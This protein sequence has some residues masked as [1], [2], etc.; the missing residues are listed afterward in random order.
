MTAERGEDIARSRQEILDAIGST[1]DLAFIRPSGTG[2]LGDELIWAGTRRLLGDRAY[3]EI[4]V[5]E[6]PRASG[7][8]ALICGGG[9][10]CHSRHELMP[11]VLAVAE[12]RFERVILLPSSFDTSVDV[13]RDTLAR[14][15]A[16]IFARER[17]S[18]ALIRELCDARIAH[19]CA[20]FFD[21]ASHARTGVGRLLA[22][23]TDAESAGE[24]PIP[25][26][27]DDISLT[28]PTLDRW[29]ELIAGHELIWT[30]R[31][32]V[33]I[34]GAMLGKTVEYAPSDYFK[35]P[36]LADYALDGFPVRRMK[37]V[38]A[39]TQAPPRLA[40]IPCSPQVM[41]VR[42]RLRAHAEASPPPPIERARDRTG[43]PRVT[44]V[45]LT[46]NRP[47]CVLGSLY[48]L[49]N[50][51]SVP[52]KILVL[53]N[54]SAPSARRRLA[55][56]C[57]AHPRI[58][59]H[60]SDRNLGAAGGRQLAVEL[61]DTELTFFLDDDAEILPGA[62]ERLIWELD[63]HPEVAALAPVVVLPD[64]RVADTGG[65]LEESRETVV[66]TPVIT[67]IQFDDP[68]L[69]PSGRCDWIAGMCLA[70]TSLFAEFPLD[71]K[72]AA[73][74]EDAEWSY[75]V[76]RGK[77]DS[78]RRVRESLILHHPDHK[79]GWR[80]DFIGRAN[81]T[82]F[83]AT[84]AYFYRT[85]G[86]LIR[87]PGMDVFAMMPELT[88]TD[89]TFDLR[90]A[91]LVMELANTHSRDWLLMEWM[92]GGLDPVLGVERARPGDELHECRLAINELRAEL[93]AARGPVRRLLGR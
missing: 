64:G 92:N 70:R 90:G 18:H 28:A 81:L 9:G 60:L 1:Q 49:L 36:A 44:A 87:V 37:S 71:T 89:G 27:N 61:L 85:H 30:D 57:A 56:A 14:T 13:V 53:D 58:D 38:A 11:H 59:L 51:P 12:M 80:R 34:A 79:S 8:T 20:F 47:E 21:Y 46:H 45:V 26:E 74:F 29:I 55:E 54:N 6:L 76:L 23:R 24:R 52:L 7:H 10:F 3:R 39:H 73:Y 88:S 15:R 16:T 43:A 86:R 25:P 19:D 31:A 4:D 77:P 42:E 33:V 78:F 50:V 5:E 84:E 41:A 40:P 68:A 63:M 65:W 67:G 22:L 91:R 17:E 75:R 32:Q 66:F 93:A 48:S 2:N 35:I 72:M 82:R 83:I 62:L 69:P